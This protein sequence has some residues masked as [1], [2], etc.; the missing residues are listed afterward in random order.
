MKRTGLAVLLLFLLV[1]AG[2][3]EEFESPNMSVERYIEL[4]KAGK[5]DDSALPAFSSEDIPKLLSFR[6]ESQ[7]IAN[8]PIYPLSSSLAGECTLGMYVLWTVESIRAKSVDNAYLMGGFPSQQ[9]MVMKKENFEYIEQNQEVQKEVADSYFNW[10]ES[11]KNQDLSEFDDS[12]P[13][14]STDYRW[15]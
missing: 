13:L 12:D 7:I 3:K 11:N 2:C 1:F 10:W 8:Y 4:L 9:P 5:Y 15:F 14:E 6:N